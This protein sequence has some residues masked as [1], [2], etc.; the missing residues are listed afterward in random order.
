MKA[1]EPVKAARQGKPRASRK[2]AGGQQSTRSVG[3]EGPGLEKQGQGSERPDRGSEKPD[4]GSRKHTQGSTTQ[5]GRGEKHKVRE[6]EKPGVRKTGPGVKKT[7]RGEKNRVRGQKNIGP[8][9]IQASNAS[10]TKPNCDKA[11]GR[12]LVLSH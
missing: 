5:G 9:N 4:R 6:I 11:V 7:G 1:L 10:G 8:K 2:K 12:L 3:G